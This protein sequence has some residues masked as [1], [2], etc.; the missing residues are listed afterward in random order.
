MISR[1]LVYLAEERRLDDASGLFETAV[2]GEGVR[3][4]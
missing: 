2:P 3:C 1:A 4:R